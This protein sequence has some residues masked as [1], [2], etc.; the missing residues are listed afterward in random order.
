MNVITIPAAEK[1]RIMLVSIML[2]FKVDS[3]SNWPPKE[4][5]G[6]IKPTGFSYPP[7]SWKHNFYAFI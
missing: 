7:A 3:E 1:N 2:L 5:E 6:A 4:I